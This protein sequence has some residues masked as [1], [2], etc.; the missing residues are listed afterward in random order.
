MILYNFILEVVCYYDF[1]FIGILGFLCVYYK[2]VINVN[3]NG[4]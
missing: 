4:F 1:G 3:L 2:V